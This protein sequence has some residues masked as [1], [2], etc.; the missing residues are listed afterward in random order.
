MLETDT[1]RPFRSARSSRSCNATHP[2]S[3]FQEILD[4][5]RH[6]PH[7]SQRRQPDL[8]VTANNIANVSTTGFKGSR[9][10]FADLFAVSQQGVSA[11]RSA[12]ACRVSDVAQQFTQGNIDFTDNNLDLAISGR[13]SSS[14]S[15]G[16]A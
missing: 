5:I 2:N 6:C 16:G 13:A 4:A 1:R 15:D 8:N 9:A 10:E 14:L 3:N 12:T 11:P 7:R